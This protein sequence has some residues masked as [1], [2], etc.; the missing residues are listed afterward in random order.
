MLKEKIC[1][2][3][4]ETSHGAR[5]KLSSKATKSR[6]AGTKDKRQKT[7]ETGMKK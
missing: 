7:K 3:E 2:G 4:V 5:Q 6:L 1:G